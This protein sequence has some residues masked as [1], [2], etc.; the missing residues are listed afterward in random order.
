MLSGK[1]CRR[2]GQS[3]ERE[4][5]SLLQDRL[6]LDLSR[7]LDQTRDGGYDILGI[8]QLAIE[9][10][11][12]ENLSIPSW[13]SQAAKQANKDQY[14]VLAY[15]QSRKPWTIIVPAK[16]VNSKLSNNS[17]VTIDIDLFCDLITL[18]FKIKKK[19]QSKV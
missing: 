11:R 3:G 5:I 1:S 9:V 14:P 19:K 6:E 12:Q 2:K 8:P 10:K 17:L 4:F 7:N 18:N 15:R 16:F 13:W